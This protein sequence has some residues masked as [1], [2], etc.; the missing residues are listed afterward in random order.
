MRAARVGPWAALAALAFGAA[1]SP[2]RAQVSAGL[3][4]DWNG[5]YVWHGLVRSPAEVLQGG[6]YARLG[7]GPASLAAGGWTNLQLRRGRPGDWTERDDD[8][9]IVTETNGWA[10]LGLAGEQLDL[11]LGA[12]HYDYCGTGAPAQRT[13]RDDTQELYAR[14]T[15]S[16]LPLTPSLIAWWDVNRARGGFVEASLTAPLPLVPM[17]ANLD[18]ITT[19]GASLG[20]ERDPTDAAETFVAERRGLTYVDLGMAANVALGSASARLSLHVQFNLDDAARRF[21]PAR[22]GDVFAWVGLGFGAARRWGPGR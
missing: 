9:W 20:Q 18:V 17:F 6:V 16:R 15:A 22:S 3:D 11:R 8:C 21:G 7:L 19:A 10:E 14:L 5:T 2:L 12:V 13:T 4:L 1:S